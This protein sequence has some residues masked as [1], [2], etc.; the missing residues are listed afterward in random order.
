MSDSG[1][2]RWARVRRLFEAAEALEGDARMAFLDTETSEDPELRAEVESL[3]AAANDDSEFLE[4]DVSTEALALIATDAESDPRVGRVLGSYKLVHELG[5]GGMGVV[6][7]AE[8]VDGE[9]EQ[10][11]AIKILH[12]GPLR[13]DL[14]ER[15][16]RE[17]EILASLNHPHIGALLDGGIS[18]DGPYLVMEFVDGRPIDTYCDEER[19]TIAERLALFRSVCDAVH[20]AHQKLV[21]HRDLKPSNVLVT[22]EGHVKLLD[23]GIARLIGEEASRARPLTRTGAR[24]LTTEYASPEQVLGQPISTSSDVYTLGVLLYEL[25]AGRRPYDLR[26]LS[27]G[28]IER[29]IVDESPVRPS[30]SVTAEESAPTTGGLEDPKQIGAARRTTPERLRKRLSG[31]LDTIVLK[32]MSKDPARRYE[33]AA[34]LSEDV[35]R[36]LANLPVLARPDSFAYRT[37]TFIRRHKFGVAAS[38]VIAASVIGG[39]FATAY[40]ASR[41]G[42]RFQDLRELSN[43]L[44]FDLHD[45]VRDLPGATAARERLVSSAL[46]Y[47]DLLRQEESDDPELL[48]DLATA[49]EQVGLI[50]GDP[51]YTN[52]GDLEGAKESY[53]RGLSLVEG[54]WQADSLNPDVAHRYARLLGRNA[55]V[56]SWSGGRNSLE[57]GPRAMEIL[58]ALQEDDPDAW[59]VSHD[60]GRIQ[61]E[62]GW[63][64][65]FEGDLSGGLAE[66]DQAI[67]VLEGVASTTNDLEAR[68]DLWR[69]YTYELDGLR[70]SPQTERAMERLTEVALPHLQDIAAT[71]PNQPRVHYGL[72]IAHYYLGNFHGHF[73][74]YEASLAAHEESR[75]WAERLVELNPANQ[76]AYEA[77]ARVYGG[78]GETNRL[79]ARYDDALEAFDQATGIHAEMYRNN[80]ENSSLGNQL[81]GA[82]RFGCR[83]VLATG[84]YDEAHKRCLESAQ[85]QRSIS[86][87]ETGGR[88]YDTNLASALSYVGDAL[89]GKAAASPS[90]SERQQLY[91]EAIDWYVRSQTILG[92]SKNQNL[93][94]EVHP[95]TVARRLEDVRT[96]LSATT[97]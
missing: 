66:I 56:D 6:Y 78:I 90:T 93:L 89:R 55:V 39:S 26:G 71:H 97:N 11:V 14:I 87:V 20:F 68:L 25:V 65:I 91:L 63:Y 41:A 35:G 18:E 1:V 48:L 44:L 4:H 69:A 7:L 10:Q 82:Q 23:F 40:Q 95:D 32:A 22:K 83:V 27:P 19:L 80:P 33:S 42:A 34:Q 85:L 15:L 45:E 92:P 49:Y 21:V 2:E 47:L 9:F 94:Y 81:A 30:T 96:Q 38:L 62:Y 86:D 5:A 46:T 74:E 43:A 76:K 3:L 88:V 79:L 72:H 57:W 16:K 70:F 77:L 60:L 50:Q 52:L 64:L 29:A 75:R 73:E 61:S 58:R 28:G 36:H 59:D 13:A 67:E 54:L 84:D 8:R 51:H 53:G 17:R 24:L 12:G 37:Q 31:D